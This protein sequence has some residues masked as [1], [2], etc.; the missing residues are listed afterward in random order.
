M[1]LAVIVDTFPRWSER[2]IARECNEL[3]RRGVQLSIFC[4]KGSAGP[5]AGDDPVSDPEFAP[6]LP[7]RVVLP[8]GFS[9]LT[10]P[11]NDDPETSRR[12]QLAREEVG[13]RQVWRARCLAVQLRSGGFTHVHA[14]FASLPSTL[15]WAATAGIS[16]S[17]SVHARDVFVEPQLLNVKLRDCTQLFTCHRRAFEHLAQLERDAGISG[18]V[19][20]MHHGLPLEQFPV[21]ERKITG[22][23][24]LLAAG[25]FVQK[26]GFATLIEALADARLSQ[27]DWSLTLLGDGAEKPKLEA[28]IE[29]RGVQNKVSLRPAVVGTELR[30]LFDQSDVFVAPNE[31]APDGDA[32]GVPNTVLEAFA[33]GLPVIG[34]QA[35][36]LSEV[37]NEQT[38]TVVPEK[39]PQALAQALLS[40]LEDPAPVL[41]KTATARARIEAE[42]DIRKN[43]DA[44]LVRSS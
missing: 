30:E 10:A 24:K 11:K 19:K 40:L 44:F 41:A 35:G 20:L 37:L 31:T 25:R 18:K 6:L 32:D 1:K 7:L 43:M 38:G 2:F 9:L 5:G 26:K 34:T 36:S 22:A 13:L 4:L 23:L 8:S 33:L 29:Q 42:Y 3:V 15:A 16:F 21:R 12:E 27:R 39:R 14:H 17:L 28:L